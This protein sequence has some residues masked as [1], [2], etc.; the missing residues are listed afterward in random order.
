MFEKTFLPYALNTYNEL[1]HDPIDCCV[2]EKTESVIEVL[3][4][5]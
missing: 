4:F 5:F 1:T 3:N 2:K